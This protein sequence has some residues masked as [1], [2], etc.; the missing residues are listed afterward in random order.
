[1]FTKFK[2]HVANMLY[3]M[4]KKQ[5]LFDHRTENVT[6]SEGAN[7]IAKGSYTPGFVV[8]ETIFYYECVQEKNC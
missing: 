8:H 6:N 1:M 7:I 4:G 3:R 2:A 5:L